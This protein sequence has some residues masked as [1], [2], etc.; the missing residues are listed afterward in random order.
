MVLSAKTQNHNWFLSY[1]SQVYKKS[2]KKFET[3][4]G[5]T[6]SDHIKLFQKVDTSCT[7]F[8]HSL[9]HNVNI[10]LKKSIQKNNNNINLAD[11]I[12]SLSG[13][14]HHIFV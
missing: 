4:I 12:T 11:P 5:K 2:L 8:K 13:Y 9:L 1:K 10:F 6:V 3:R 7:I 14:T